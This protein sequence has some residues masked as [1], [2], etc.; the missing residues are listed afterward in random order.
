MSEN[1]TVLH[2]FCL[3]GLQNEMLLRSRFGRAL[4]RNLGAFWT[5]LAGF[6]L[7]LKGRIFEVQV[8][9]PKREAG[10]MEGASTHWSCG[11]N[12]V[13]QSIVDIMDH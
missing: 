3:R 8:R 2:Y 11:P 10:D 13:V 5:I 7:F 4:G 9:S 1:V 12:I 6:W